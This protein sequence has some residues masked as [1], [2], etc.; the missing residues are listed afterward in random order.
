MFKDFL[1]IIPAR[2][3][4][5]GIQGKN[6]KLLGRKPLI[7]YSLEVAREFTTVDNICISTDSNTIIKLAE[8]LGYKIPFVRPSFL[9]TDTATTYD[10]IMH[11]I[12]FYEHQ[13]N[14]YDHIILL[15]PTSPFRKTWQVQEMMD[16]WTPGIDMI[17]SVKMAKANPYYNL[18]EENT[19]GFL[20]K[21]KE[22]NF[23]RR[24]DCPVVYEY[25]GA[26]Y[27]IS[28]E[29]LR[30]MNIS[31]FSRVKKY[32]MDEQSSIDLDTE[33][34]WKFAEFLLTNENI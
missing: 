31:G 28:T 30:R 6:Y 27:L 14:N 9:A 10:V 19:E 23:S 7:Q 12:E 2:E 34:D 15:Q 13:G 32:I 20:R 25:N 26:I 17:V 11:A 8:K 3:G 21:S 5:K 18:F 24:Q 29:S 22:D 4:S 33:L 1:V 16:L